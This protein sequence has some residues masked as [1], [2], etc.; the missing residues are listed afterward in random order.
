M[1]KPNTV[2]IVG[3]GASYEL[4]FPT[5]ASLKDEIASTLYF[6]PTTLNRTDPI[7]DS[8]IP[9]YQQIHGIDGKTIKY[10]H[11]LVKSREFIENI[12]V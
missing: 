11:Q 8:D 9:I 12:S 5:G 2:F 7:K 6:E 1:F 10:F 3:A 4:G